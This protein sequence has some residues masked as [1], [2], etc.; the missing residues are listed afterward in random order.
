M[1]FFNL[2]FASIIISAITISCVK[3]YESRMGNKY[4]NSDYTTSGSY[5]ASVGKETSSSDNKDGNSGD[6]ILSNDYL[7]IYHDESGEVTVSF[8]IEHEIP[9]AIGE[10]M[11]E[12]DERAYMNGQGWKGVLDFVIKKRC[13]EILKGMNTDCEAGTYTAFYSDNK[14]GIKNAK[15]LGELIISLI[16][17]EE[18]LYDIVRNHADEI[19]WDDIEE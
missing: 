18:E 4:H 6:I 12:I 13:P 17:H 5:N 16:E 19:E 9:F 3:F 11:E 15:K 2:L 7:N 14:D 8:N 10:K 1:N